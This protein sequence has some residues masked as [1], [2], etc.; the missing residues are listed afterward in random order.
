MKWV[1]ISGMILVGLGIV[2]AIAFGFMPKPVESEFARAS[3]GDIRVSIDEE[4]HTRV[5]DRFT[6]S[7]P[8]AGEIARINLKAGDS[9]EAGAVIT[10]LQP[11]PPVLLDARGKAQAQANAQAAEAAVSQ[12]GASFD[13]AQAQLDLAVKERERLD[14]L[15]A[16]EQVSREQVEAAKLK[17]AAAAANLKSAEFGKAVAGFQ[18]DM[19]NAALIEGNAGSTLE[20]IEI[21]SPVA[22]EVLR[23]Y[24]ESAGPVQPGEMLIEIGDPHS[25]EVVVDL[26]SSDAV[27][28]KPDMKVSIERWGG[29]EPLEGKVRRI[30]PSGFTKVS[31]LGVEEQ[32]VN[33]VIDFVG[34]PEAWARL[35]DQFR[36][37]ARVITSERKDVVKVPAGALFNTPEGTAVF[38]VV[39]DRARQR[40]VE[41]GERN[42]LE[43]EILTKLNE[44]DTVI[45]HPS[46]EIEDGKPVKAR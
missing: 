7:A 43:A 22:G 46:D 36:V 14:K 29:D 31:S 34:K 45:V 33:V 1:K 30:E 39:D 25:L 28:V 24:H 11:A 27:R 19:A 42:G 6:I 44:G 8:T 40:V 2:A 16:P 10:V 32:R 41:V 26:L 3:R 35:G 38:V 37:E 4:G 23:V 5:K 17:E 13:A 18:R 20:S 21:R 15:K 12:A 9:V